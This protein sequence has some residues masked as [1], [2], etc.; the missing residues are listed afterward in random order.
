MSDALSL[1]LQSRLMLL[2]KALEKNLSSP[3]LVSGG[4]QQSLAFLYRVWLSLLLL[5][6]PVASLVVSSVWMSSRGFSLCGSG[7]SFSSSSKDNGDWKG[8]GLTLICYEL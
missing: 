7:A 2:P 6:L 5:H 1:S 4:G 8:S 3:L